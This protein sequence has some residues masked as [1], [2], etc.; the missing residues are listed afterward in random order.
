MSHGFR[1]DARRSLPDSGQG[2]SETS[3]EDGV[4]YAERRAVPSLARVVDAIWIAG[5][6][7]EAGE[8]R[9]ILPDA[10]ADLIL[11]LE[12]PGRPTWLELNGPPTRSFVSGE[13]GPRF[14][15]G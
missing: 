9:V 3:V 15:V 13:T 12:R 5:R 11:R 2:A 6:P 1:K 14:L 8:S 7:A 10:H 4:F